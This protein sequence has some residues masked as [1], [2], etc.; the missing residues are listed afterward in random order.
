[1]KFGA[2]LL[3]LLIILLV[4]D[5]SS[6]LWRR[7]RRRRRNTNFNIKNGIN[8]RSNNG[9]HNI[10]VNY[11]NA[12][13][14]FNGR[15]WNANVNHAWRNGQ[16]N[17]NANR[18][19]HNFGL[20]HNWRNRQ[21]NFR[22]RYTWGRRRRSIDLQDDLKIE[23]K[24]NVFQKKLQL[25]VKEFIKRYK[26]VVPHLTNLSISDGVGQI[27]NATVAQEIVCVV[28]KL[29]KILPKT[30]G[31]FITKMINHH[32]D[33]FDVKDFFSIGSAKQQNACEI[34][35]VPEG[36]EIKNPQTLMEIKQFITTLIVAGME[37][38]QMLN[39]IF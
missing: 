2:I 9:R 26:N 30:L 4:A 31:K 39:N 3:F 34:P 5:F 12:N 16:T 19:R 22:Y 8:H 33:S 1:M 18:G 6:G 14:R 17:I 11:R 29:Q 25:A 27:T 7:R 28:K 15:R 20:G 36:E 13:Y 38:E 10:N 23:R 24:P 21:T 35:D 32:G 37:Y